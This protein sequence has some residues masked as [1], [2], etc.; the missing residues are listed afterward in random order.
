MV[1][2]LLIIHSLLTQFL[3]IKCLCAHLPQQLAQILLSS[4]KT[5]AAVCPIHTFTLL[6]IAYCSELANSSFIQNWEWVCVL[7]LINHQIHK[8]RHVLSRPH[9]LMEHLPGKIQ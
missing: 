7:F 3:N 1:H 9:Y 4:Y 6:L 8:S 5:P 2:H